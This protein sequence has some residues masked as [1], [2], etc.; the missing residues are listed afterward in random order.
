MSNDG[1]APTPAQIASIAA[2]LRLSEGDDLASLVRTAIRL[3]H[4]SELKLGELARFEKE[5]SKNREDWFILDGDESKRRAWLSGEKPITLELRAEIEMRVRQ[6]ELD[7]KNIGAQ[8][9][10]AKRLFYLQDVA[11]KVLPQ[12]NQT[13]RARTAS[14]YIQKEIES[15]GAETPF[16]NWLSINQR[17]KVEAREAWWVFAEILIRRQ[18]TEGRFRKGNRWLESL[19]KRRRDSQPQGR[20]KK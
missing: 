6:G 4:L 12:S 13:D 11:D 10:P 9:P 15:V 18:R 1:S 8:G 5:V 3:W 14:R 17:Q 16:G 19:A 20:W 2:S 7:T